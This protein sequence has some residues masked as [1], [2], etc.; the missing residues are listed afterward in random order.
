MV[1]DVTKEKTFESVAKWI[2]ELKTNAEP[3]IVII[4]VGNKVDLCE[5]NP[6]MRGVK[7]EDAKKFAA[8]N[9][10]LFCESSAITSQNVSDAFENLLQGILVIII[11]CSFIPKKFMTRETESSLEQQVV[12]YLRLQITRKKIREAVAK[13]KEFQKNIFCAIT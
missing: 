2:E 4:L 11:P 1:Y 5:N 13:F 8:A 9:G 12:K 3:D 6:T 10:L 7:V